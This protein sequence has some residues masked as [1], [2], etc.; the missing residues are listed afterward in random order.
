[1]GEQ[2]VTPYRGPDARLAAPAH[3]QTVLADGVLT[4]AL[5]RPGKRNAIDAA[6][7]MV[8]QQ[9]LEAASSDPDVRVV[10]LKGEGDGFSAGIDTM[11]AAAASGSAPGPDPLAV[12][13]HCRTNVMPLM[14]QPVIAMVHGHCEGEAFGLVEACDIALAADDAVFVAALSGR[15]FD[16]AEAERAG[17]VTRSVPAAELE[18]QVDAL[19]A[20]LAAKDPLAL[21]FTKETLL[22]VGSLDWDAVL[23]FNAAKVAQLKA[24]QAGRPSARATLV[25]SFLAGK[26]KPGLG[27]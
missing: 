18:A 2:Q 3:L 17:L 1:M 26:S 6:L 4:L 21:R 24:L 10:V 27:G 25:E 23:D 8:L 15:P 13:D 14:A 9:V 16:G 7:A 12:L 5:D 11:K 19:A 22:H 20:E